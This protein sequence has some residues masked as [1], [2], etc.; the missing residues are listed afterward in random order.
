MLRRPRTSTA[1]G[2]AEL[3]LLWIDRIRLALRRRWD[4][5][6]ATLVDSRFVER[7]L[8]SSDNPSSFQIWE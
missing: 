7:K 5:I 3:P 1:A 8:Y 2:R 4:R 6:D